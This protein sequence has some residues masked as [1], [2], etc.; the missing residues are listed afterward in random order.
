MPLKFNS[1]VTDTNGS[2]VDEISGKEL[3][4][5]IVRIS[6]EIKEDTNA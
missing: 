1:T 3:K 5:V 2:E 4:K 6:N